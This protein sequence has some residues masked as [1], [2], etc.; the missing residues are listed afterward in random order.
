[1]LVQE[2]VTKVVSLFEDN[3]DHFPTTERPTM[4]WKKMHEDG[5]FE[6]IFLL[7]NEELDE[8]HSVK[9]VINV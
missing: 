8:T 1:M 6:E 2:N 4:E 5:S 3:Q 7:L 9:K